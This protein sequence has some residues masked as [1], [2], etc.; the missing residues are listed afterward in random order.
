M[1][2]DILTQGEQFADHLQPDT[3][4]PP[5]GVMQVGRAFTRGKSGPVPGL[6]ILNSPHRGKI[7]AMLFIE[8]LPLERVRR[9]MEEEMDLH[10]SRT[11]LRNY[12]D[13]HS[14][15]TFADVTAIPGAIVL[16]QV[17]KDYQNLYNVLNAVVKEAWRLI[18]LKKVTV[19]D[20]LKA[21]DLMLSM[22]EGDQNHALRMVTAEEKYH[23][24]LQSVIRIINDVCD[25]DTKL[26]IQGALMEDPDFIA[27]MK[28]HIT[29]DEEDET[30]TQPL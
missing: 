26:K 3:L 19:R 23:L 10:V 29:T 6:R 5:S 17:E 14:Q 4:P 30:V 25:E 28:A 16:D 1:T 20:S 12:F 13:H 24:G 18:D 27:A 8:R 9:I 15:T 21:A 11:Q 22:V 2:R 7:N